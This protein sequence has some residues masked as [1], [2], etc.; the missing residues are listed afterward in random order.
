MKLSK[1]QEASIETSSVAS[2][3]PPYEEALASTSANATS[4]KW[5]GSCY[6]IWMSQ[7]ATKKQ[8]SLAKITTPDMTPLCTIH[9][10]GAY[11]HSLRI[12][13]T[14][15]G[16]NEEV[17]ADISINHE[18]SKS[19]PDLDIHVGGGVEQNSSSGGGFTISLKRDKG[20]FTRRHR[21][22]LSDGKAYIL[23]GKHSDHLMM[24][25]GNLKVVE[26]SSKAKIAEFKVE[27]PMSVHKIGVV[28]FV[29]EV[30]E[31][32]VKDVLVAFVAVASREH[33]IAMASLCVA[34]PAATA[35]AA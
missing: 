10:F 6:H 18:D 22:V 15:E 14:T 24:C 4:S 30:E 3:P 27:W 20:T 8:P 13:S 5:S 35:G 28:T 17:L 21:M 2:A 31:K 34:V 11:S 16:G 32:L 12:T 7:A 25:W 26:E 19:D 9:G 1:K 23:T 33:A 29:H